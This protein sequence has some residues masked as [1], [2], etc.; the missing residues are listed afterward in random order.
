L[1]LAPEEIRW[2]FALL[3][4]VEDVASLLDVTPQRLVWHLWQ[5]PA[6]L[7]YAHFPIRKRRGGHRVISAPTGGLKILQHKLSQVLDAVYGVKT[8]VHGFVRER[9]IKTNAMQHVHRRFILNLD[10][11]DFFPS[12]HFGRVR[13]LL[14]ARPYNCNAEVATTLAQICF[15]GERGLPQ[16]APTSP[17]V[18]NMICAGMDAKLSKLANK[19]RCT[20]T[21]YSDD[22]TI[23]TTKSRFPSALATRAP[24]VLEVGNE[25]VSA[26][27]ESGFKLNPNKQRLLTR[28]DRQEVTGLVTN[29]FVNVRRKYVRQIGAMLHAWERFGYDSA[30]AEFRTRWDT[31]HRPSDAPPSFVDVVLGKLNFLGMIRG[32]DDRLYS[33]LVERAP[34]LN[35]RLHALATRDD[36]VL[37]LER[38]VEAAL[39]DGQ[40]SP[41]TAFN[42]ANVGTVTAC[43]VVLGDGER[44]LSQMEAIRPLTPGRREE[45]NTLLHHADLDIALVTNPYPRLPAM[46]EGDPNR[47]LTGE[48]VL[49]LGYPHWGAGNRL[50]ITAARVTGRKTMFGVD[51]LLLDTTI[52]DGNSGGP[53]LNEKGEVIGVA[54]TGSSIGRHPNSM[55]PVSAIREL[56]RQM[57]VPLPVRA[58]VNTDTAQHGEAEGGSQ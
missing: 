5:R 48:T 32:R 14:M 1:A 50:Q 2:R 53:V 44:V 26:V 45:V 36:A 12:I 51:R 54:V 9:S 15:T 11:E 47:V 22:I 58:T 24:G 43:H 16:G 57:G 23:S 20:Y 10:L 18:A 19:Y 3:Q 35:G 13:G 46:K 55:V 41:G 37:V 30:E 34:L 33:Q 7:C 6:G 17:V 56:A 31:K 21:R 38:N 4:T 40:G 27:T 25:L 29:E 28:F 42:L 39:A 52:R 8:S 49:V